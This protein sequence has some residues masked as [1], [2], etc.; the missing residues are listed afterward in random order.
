MFI[1]GG[2]TLLFGI[3]DKVDTR[4]NIV[5]FVVLCFITRVLLALGSTALQN[6]GFVILV[7]SFPNNVS[8]VVAG[9][10]IL[11]FAVIGGICFTILPFSL[12]YLPPQDDTQ[13]ADEDVV[14]WR[15]VLLHPRSVV[16]SIVVIIAALVWAVLDPNLE[17]HLREYNLGP[18]LVGVMFL[19]MAAVYSVTS[20]M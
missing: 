15:H 5:T 12:A 17:P 11:P 3:L 20:P 4:E 14:S 9:G 1:C 19:I 10:F 13:E 2:C 7:K 8:T 16:N 18:E 6:A